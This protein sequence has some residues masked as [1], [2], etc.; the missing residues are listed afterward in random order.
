MLPCRP[1]I[2]CTADIVQPGALEIEA[3]WLARRVRTAGFQHGQPL[4]VKLSLSRWFQLQVGTS[5]RNFPTGDVETPASYVDG[6][7]PGLKAH[8]L[9]QTST[10]PA[11]AASLAF[12]VPSWDRPAGVP[13]ALDTT[14]WGYAS[15]DVA[16]LHFD[17]NAALS[18]LQ[19]GRGVAWQPLL[20]LAVS[21]PLGTHFGAMVEGYTFGAAGN[22]APRDGGALAALTFA[23]RPWLMF[24]A[25]VD[26]SFFPSTREYSLFL[27]LTAIPWIF[28]DAPRP[29]STASGAPLRAHRDGRAPYLG[30]LAR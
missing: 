12:R 24:D 2:A 7:S 25:G 22:V 23:P 19:I 28:G 14:L 30:S 15:K 20:A 10:V 5:G 1:T 3:G 16:F 6:V 29:V 13:F 11:L 18:A 17:L 9:D 4:L 8:F 26:T 27:G 21:V